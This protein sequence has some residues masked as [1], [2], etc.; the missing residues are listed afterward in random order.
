MSLTDRKN[1]SSKD[2]SNDASS[3]IATFVVKIYNLLSV[4]LLIMK[5]SAKR[6][7]YLLGRRRQKFYHQKYK[8]TN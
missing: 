3:S 2:C 1:G 5:G 8:F 4:A 6:I 7:G